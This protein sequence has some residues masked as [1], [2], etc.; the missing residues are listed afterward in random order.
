MVEIGDNAP[1]FRLLNQDGKGVSLEDFEGRRLII[2]F[3]PRAD[4]PGCT[5]EACGFRDGWAEFESE[6]I[7][8]VGI[9]D[10]PVAK[11]AKFH[12]KYN[13]PFDLL[14]D[15]EG[16]VCEMYDSYGEK[17]MYGKTYVG[18]KRNTYTVDSEGKITQIYLKVKV[19]DHSKKLLE[20]LEG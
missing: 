7:G 15:E 5:T 17:K 13:F 10:D 4:T 2:Y 3:Y 9:S 8:V 19:A 11:I 14:S 18:V 1:P 6:S 20:D 12:A 16:N